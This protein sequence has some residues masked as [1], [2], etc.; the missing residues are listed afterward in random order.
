MTERDFDRVVRVHGI[1]AVRRAASIFETLMPDL[2]HTRA[3][4]KARNF[5]NALRA[6]ADRAEREKR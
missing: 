5:I 2:I 1:E 3:G 4:D 6:A